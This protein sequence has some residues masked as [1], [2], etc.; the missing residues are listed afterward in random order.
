[1]EI[2]SCPIEQRDGNNNFKK[3]F[4]FDSNYN[5]RTFSKSFPVTVKWIS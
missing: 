1:M 3:Q 2:N 4:I 5:Y